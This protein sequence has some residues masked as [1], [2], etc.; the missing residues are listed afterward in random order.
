[1]NN[2][3]ALNGYFNHDNESEM[4]PL[5]ANFRL[6][7][8]LLQNMALGPQLSPG[9]QLVQSIKKKTTRAAEPMLG[10]PTVIISPQKSLIPKDTFEE[11]KQRELES[12]KAQKEGI[13]AYE[14]ELEDLKKQ[15]INPLVLALAGASDIV[16]DGNA[17]QNIMGQQAQAKQA[18]QVGKLNLQ[19]M[20]QNLTDDEIAQ[21]RAQYQHEQ[22]GK[23]A[24]AEESYKKQ[25][26]GL[27]REKLA[28]AGGDFTPGQEAADKAFGKEYQDWNAQGGFSGVNKQLDQLRAAKKAL[29]TDPGLSGGMD[30]ALPDAVRRRLYP[31]AMVIEQNVREAA[32]SALR[33]TLG[34]QFTE[35]EGAQIMQRSYDPALPAEENIKKID[36][37]IKDLSTRAL[38]KERASKHF[39]QFGTLKGYTASKQQG[40]SSGKIS[41]E[42]W[43]K[44][45]GK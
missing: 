10:A 1:M 33:Q 25:L 9:E 23:A 7:P 15:K 28:K 45:R 39:E 36:A 42:E 14:K 3:L 27:Q 16:G 2:L 24:E 40:T 22:S 13:A 38:E 18:E 26:L 11:L 30:T 43:K 44:K 6:D 32:Q 35:K 31:D 12:F 8:S 37:A 21:L 17:L 4:L 19:K 5:D 20:R 29:Q 34:S 41:F